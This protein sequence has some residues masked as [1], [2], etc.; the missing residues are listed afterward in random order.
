MN[1][2][3]KRTRMIYLNHRHCLVHAIPFLH[4]VSRNQ[5]TWNVLVY[6]YSLSGSL[7][8]NH[9]IFVMSF[10]TAHLVR[11][12]WKPAINHL[13]EHSPKLFSSHVLKAK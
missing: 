8:L 11:V 3:K 9:F 7:T 2:M 13:Q 1:I 10:T 5:T 12:G 4:K 6:Y